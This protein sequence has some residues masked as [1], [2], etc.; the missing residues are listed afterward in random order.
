MSFN[1]WIIIIVVNTIIIVI[2]I[3]I[4]II[5]DIIIVIIIIITLSE[6][7]F[8]YMAWFTLYFI[9]AIWSVFLLELYK[10]VTIT[11]SIS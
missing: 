7:A 3:V 4:V 6:I 10:K 11:S 2:I 8:Y 9:S 1:E 5:I